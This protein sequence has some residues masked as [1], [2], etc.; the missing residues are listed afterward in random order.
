M[1]YKNSAINI[2]V[3]LRIFSNMNAYST[4]IHRAPKN[5][6]RSKQIAGDLLKF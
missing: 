1:K 6:L 2:I 3:I 5:F 4:L